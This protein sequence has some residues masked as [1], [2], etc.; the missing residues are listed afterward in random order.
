MEEPH[1]GAGIRYAAVHLSH[2]CG[3]LP[4]ARQTA[5]FRHVSR[6]TIRAQGVS[7][8]SLSLLHG[9]CLW[10]YHIIQVDDGD[11]HPMMCV[12]L[13]GLSAGLHTLK[14]TFAAMTAN[15]CHL[16]R[17]QGCIK[18]MHVFEAKACSRPCALC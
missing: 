7:F 16:M 13:A 9:L 18:A 17:A 5:G 10:F 3:L 6:A 8:A 15:S 14:V 12:D 4:S 11:F 1:R 2:P